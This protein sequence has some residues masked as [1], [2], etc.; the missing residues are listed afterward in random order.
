[1]KF[2]NIN[3]NKRIKG[4]LF[5]L[6]ISP[7]QADLILI[8]APWSLTCGGLGGAVLGPESILRNSYKVGLCGERYADAW[9]I[10]MSML[11]MPNGW[12]IKS[13][14]LFD[15]VRTHVQAFEGGGEVLNAQLTGRVDQYSMAFKERVRNKGLMYMKKDKMVGLVGGEHTCALGLMEACAEKH[16]SFGILHIDAHAD[17]RESYQGFKYSD[18]SVMFHALKIKGVEVLVQVGLRDYCEEEES[19]MSK[20]GER[21]VSF[22]DDVLQR[23]RFEGR[24]WGEICGDMVAKL[25]K[26][27]YVSFDVDGLDQKLCPSTSRSV[28]GGLDLA[29]VVYLLERLV[30][31]GKEIVGFDLSEV[32]FNG[33]LEWDGMVGAYLLYRLGALMAKSQGRL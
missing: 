8:P 26:K 33:E 14:Q 24:K 20:E 4:Q 18:A 5:G 23:A 2:Q 16:K 22:T 7:D 31:E 21:V 30:D 9:R 17:L 3:P 25:P 1:M 29:E 13:N 19:L 27:V 28:P 10:G 32:A 12:K 15:S 6:P 11:P